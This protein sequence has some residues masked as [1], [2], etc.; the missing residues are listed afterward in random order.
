MTTE[1]REKIARQEGLI[2]DIGRKVIAEHPYAFRCGDTA[3]IIGWG[4]RAKDQRL[5]Y[6]IRFDNGECDAIPAGEL[7]SQS[8]FAFTDGILTNS[9]N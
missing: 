5:L 3:E 6:F 2:A 7:F 4:I 8:G 1:N 9:C